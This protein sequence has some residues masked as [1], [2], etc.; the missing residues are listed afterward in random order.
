MEKGMG[1]TNSYRLCFGTDAGKRVLGNILVEA[2][3]FDTDLK[4]PEEQ[5]VL[6]FAKKILNKMGLF[7]VKDNKLIGVDT[8]VNKL[9]EMP[10]E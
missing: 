2:G 1:Q 4:T 8:F 7:Q 9:F 6:N 3:Y 10:V 5:A